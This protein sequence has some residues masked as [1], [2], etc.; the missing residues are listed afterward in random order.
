M[1]ALAVRKDTPELCACGSRKKAASKTCL[2]CYR[3][4]PEQRPAI[5]R[6]FEKVDASAG[7]FGCW[8]WIGELDRNGY[9][10]FYLSGRMGWAHRAAYTLLVGAIPA[11]FD[12]R[13]LECDNPPCCNPAHLAV[14]THWQNVHDSINKG[15][16]NRGER[17]GTAKLTADQVRAIRAEYAGGGVLMREIAARAGVSHSLVKRIVRRE[18]WAHV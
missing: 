13:H 16:N 14:G 10:K 12:V 15:R 5:E 7:A 2:S 3:A 17:S 9:G 4:A 6:F 8:P 18:R 11:G 1:S